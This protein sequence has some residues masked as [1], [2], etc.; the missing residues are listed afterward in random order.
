MPAKSSLRAPL[1]Y[2]GNCV[3]INHGQQFLTI[4]MH[5][6]KLSVKE[7]DKVEKGQEVGSIRRNRPCYGAASARRR[8]LAGRPTWIPRSSGRYPCP[9]SRKQKTLPPATNSRL[10]ASVTNL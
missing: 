3:I 1:F 8:A 9:L 4:Y 6:S 10:R 5:L 7:G 2:E